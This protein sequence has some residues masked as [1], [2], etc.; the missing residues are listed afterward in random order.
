[1]SD[2]SKTTAFG[3]LGNDLEAGNSRR[4]Y[5]DDDD[6]GSGPFDIVRTKRAPVHRL[7][8]WRVS[9]VDSLFL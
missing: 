6:D 1:M 9:Q 8:R 7:R 5:V 4:D 3:P 2:D